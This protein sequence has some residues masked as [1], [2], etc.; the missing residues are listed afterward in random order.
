MAWLKRNLFNYKFELLLALIVPFLL[1]ARLTTFPPL[2]FTEGW[3]LSIARNWVKLGN[4]CQLMAGKPVS[5]SMLNVGFPA[6]APVALSFRLLGVGIWQGRLPFVLF[7]LGSLILVYQL[8]TRLYCRSIARGALAVLLL[9]STV[10]GVNPLGVGKM[11]L[12]EMP[13]MFY[14]LAG[15][16]FFIRSLSMSSFIS[17]LFTCTF[18]GLALITK[19]QPLPFLVVSLAVV[20]SLLVLRRSWRLSWLVGASLPGALLSFGVMSLIQQGLLHDRALVETQPGIFGVTAF[21]PVLSVRLLAMTSALLFASPA[22]LGICHGARRCLRD[23]RAVA[24]GELEAARLSLLILVGT[25]MAWCLLLA[26]AGTRYLFPPAFLGSIFFSRMVYDLTD[27]FDF[28]LAL[29]RAAESM[30]RK[31]GKR[32]ITALLMLLYITFAVSI[33]L[34]DMALAY[35][36]ADGSVIDT[37]EYIN[38]CTRPGSLIETYDMEL[39]FMLDRPCHYPANPTLIKLDRRFVLGK[40]VSIGYDPLKANPDYLIVGPMTRTWRLYDAVLQ[41]GAFRLVK[42]CGGYAIYKRSRR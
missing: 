36:G 19:L 34:K 3:V 7:T 24:V 8:A 12:G 26:S 11:A 33:T 42:R 2:M 16:L 17:L 15:Y 22:L 23:W 20:S 41:T 13:S 40:K 29:K 31:C 30:G 1:T 6:I 18:W 28:R 14:L 39:S 10:A 35:A 37:A 9:M 21:V 4:Y 38:S 32:S 27:G 5:A 25:W